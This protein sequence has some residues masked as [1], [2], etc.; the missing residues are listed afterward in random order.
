MVYFPNSAD[1]E[2]IVPFAIGF[3][4]G[5]LQGIG[6]LRAQIGV[7]R[8]QV[9]GVGKIGVGHELEEVRPVD[10]ADCNSLE[11]PVCRQYFL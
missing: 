3:L 6:E 11:G 4:I 10:L 9:K 8:L 7:T 2:I 1:K 5:Q